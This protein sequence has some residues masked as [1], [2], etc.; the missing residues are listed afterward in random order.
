[1]LH[2]RV[3]LVLCAQHVHVLRH[4]VVRVGDCVLQRQMLQTGSGL[5]VGPLRRFD[6]LIAAES[7]FNHR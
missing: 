1:V 3:A 4:H 6:R 5:F 2:D 7:W